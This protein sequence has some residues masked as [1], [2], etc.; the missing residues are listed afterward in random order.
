MTQ[1]DM[2]SSGAAPKASTDTKQAGFVA[3]HEWTVVGL[4][5]VLA[6]VLGCIGYAQ[7]MTFAS[8]GG[9]HTWWDVIYASLQLFIF[10]GP[11]ATSGWPLHLQIARMLAPMV[12][13]Y[14]AAQAVW[15]RVHQRVALYWLL[16]SKRRFVVI[17]GIGET[18]FR[19]ARDYCLHSE[20]KVVVIDLDPFNAMAAELKNCG[21]IVLCGNAMD[22]LMLLDSRVVYAKE[23]F[24]CTSDDKANIAIAKNVERLT[25]RL[26]EREIQ[27]LELIAGKYERP[28]AGEPPHLGLRCFLCVDAPDLYEVFSAHSFFEA[29]SLRFAVRLFNRR[30]S[31]AR[32]IFR[33]CAPDL[34]Y[35]PVNKASYPMHIL[36]IGFEALT[37]EMILQA[38]L[39]AHYTDFRIPRVTVLCPE[40]RRE[41]VERFLHRYPHLEETVRIEFVYHDPM[42][43]SAS[44]W[45]EMQSVTSFSVC[46]VA[47]QHDVEGILSAR[48]LNRQR[49]LGGLA[50]LNFVVCLNQQNFLAEII[51]DDFLSITLDKSRLPEHEPIE[52]FETLDETISINVVVNEAL[53]TLARTMH[54]A[55][56][57]TL[58]ARGGSAENNASLIKWSELPEHKKRANRHAAAHIDVK[59]RIANCVAYGL[60]AAAPE[61]AFPPDTQTLELLAQLEHRRWMADKHLAGYSYGELRDEDRMLHPDLIPWEKLSEADREKD[62]DSIHQIPKLLKLQYQ[63]VC[64]LT[65]T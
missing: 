31:I 30:E 8:A 34:Y 62:R 40:D 25:R 3:R 27:R 37:R 10:E 4:L 16:F 49:R 22:P 54:N 61:V 33:V 52:Y 5:A 14:T 18:G 45:R 47:V 1:P 29:N 59:L 7:T 6:Y 12:L 28:I 53:D 60:E 63:K 38:A 24:L 48:R 39:T 21:A 50:A 17:C 9:E 23:L 19:I 36:F 55:Y 26:S 41:Q 20:K 44:E 51:D 42:T 43:I 65:I 15:R 57:K 32:N 2:H 64:L 56:L 46:Y 13:L 35:R 58:L 11:D